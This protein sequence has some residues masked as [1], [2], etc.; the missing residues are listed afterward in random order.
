[1]LLP[2]NS[3]QQPDVSTHLIIFFF[4]L[5]AEIVT[6]AR[7][8]GR[9]RQSDCPEYPFWP[10]LILAEIK[11]PSDDEAKSSEILEI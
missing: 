6:G 7:A 9:W 5:V 1:M 2:V 8:A 4:L 3:I 10:A 11:S